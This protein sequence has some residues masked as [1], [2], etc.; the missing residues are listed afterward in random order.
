M[1]ELR[2]AVFAAD[3]RHV[4]A[5]DGDVRGRGGLRAVLV[6][7]ALHDLGLRVDDDDN[8]KWGGHLTPDG[9]RVDVRGGI[10]DVVWEER[11]R[12]FVFPDDVERVGPRLRVR[13]YF[14]V[15]GVQEV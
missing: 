8:E 11:Q 1:I 9:W 6:V 13:P 15:V 10:I 5:A 12:R 7:M 3:G 14:D 2:P 4:I